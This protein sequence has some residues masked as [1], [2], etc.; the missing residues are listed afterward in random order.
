[1]R[2]H[3]LNGDAMIDFLSKNIRY[4][5]ISGKRFPTGAWDECRTCNNRMLFL[6]TERAIAFVVSDA[7]QQAM[8]VRTLLIILIGW[9]CGRPVL[10]CSMRCKEQF[11]YCVSIREKEK[12][13][14]RHLYDDCLELCDRYLI[15]SVQPIISPKTSP[16]ASPEEDDA[17]KAFKL[18]DIL[19]ALMSD[20]ELDDSAVEEQFAVDNPLGI[21]DFIH[22]EAPEVT[23]RA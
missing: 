15:A 21:F 12:C 19:T 5:F 20:P 23:P 7:K 1:M 22:E 6:E 17:S 11:E 8:T 16:E 13:S 3:V 4:A 2:L 14:E 10:E 9:A 18:L